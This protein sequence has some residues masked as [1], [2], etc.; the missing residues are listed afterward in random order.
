MRRRSI[1]VFSVLGLAP[2]GLARAGDETAASRLIQ[3]KDL[4]EKNR[5]LLHGVTDHYTL[6]REYPVR[7][8]HASYPVFECLLDHMEACAVLAQMTGLS[9]Y[10][11]RL[12][13][14]G[15]L[16]AD[17]HAGAAGYLIGVYAG[18]GKRVLYVEGTH[19]Q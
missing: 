2:V 5:V 18:E 11:A 10:R 16:W 13:D 19:R 7:E 8:V 3:F 9:K 14:Q 6:R 4:T 1:L 15:R 17:N 12:D